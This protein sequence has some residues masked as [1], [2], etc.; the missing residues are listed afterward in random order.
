MNT[1]S[2][3]TSRQHASTATTTVAPV[4]NP[5][6]RRRGALCS[7]AEGR[8]HCNSL[9]RAPRAVGVLAQR[10]TALNLPNSLPGLGGP[11]VLGGAA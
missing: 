8:S 4:R 5:P 2:T 1:S 11:T 7:I 6:A 10:S 3:T 9:R